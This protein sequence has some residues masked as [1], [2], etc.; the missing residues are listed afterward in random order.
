[1][2]LRGSAFGVIEGR[3]LR[4]SFIYRVWERE[5]DERSPTADVMM[6]INHESLVEVGDLV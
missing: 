4:K 6:S 5:N 1:M 2:L 3:A